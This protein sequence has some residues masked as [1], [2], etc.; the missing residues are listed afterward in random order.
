VIAEAWYADEKSFAL[1]YLESLS[2]G[3]PRMAV[4]LTED[5]DRRHRRCGRVGSL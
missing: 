1:Q 3:L 5:R 4:L 2:A